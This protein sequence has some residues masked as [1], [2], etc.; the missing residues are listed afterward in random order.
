DIGEILSNGAVKI[1]DRK[2]NLIKLSQG[3]YVA[4]EYLEKIYGITPIVEDLWIHGDSFKSQL[5]AVVV[6][7]E[8][9]TKKWAEQNGYT[10]SFQKLCSLSQLKPHILLELKST[11]ERNKL[12]G[13]EQIRGVII[14]PELFES[15][16][17][18]LVTAT[19]KKRRD[20]FL[21]RYKAEINTLYQKLAE[22]KS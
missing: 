12:R 6:P 7:N 11:A 10:G 9:N 8:E 21:K 3:E 19:L 16:E 5:V 2:K 20:R 13:F 17:K 14:E 15:P 1:I 4:V 22:A 18:E